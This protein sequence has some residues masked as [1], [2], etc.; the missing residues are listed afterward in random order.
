MTINLPSPPDDDP[1]NV[2]YTNRVFVQALFPYRNT[3]DYRRSITQGSNEV[4]ITSPNGL[5]YGKYPRLIMAYII[6]VAVQRAKQVE[7][8]LFTEEEARRIPL[9]ESLNEF[10]RSI[11]SAT[12]GTGGSNGTI[13]RI[14]EQ[15]VRL[16][17]STITVQSRMERGT[18]TLH[19]GVNQSIA[20]AWQLWFDSGNPDQT[21]LEESYIQLTPRF[22]EIICQSPIPIDLNVLQQLGK[23][24]AMDIYVWIT[25]KKAW[26]HYRNLPSYTFSW[27]EMEHQFST[28]KLT[29]SVQR[30]N[31]RNEFNG[32]LKVIQSLWPGIGVT[33]DT[34]SGVTIYKGAPSISM[35]TAKPKLP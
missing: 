9:G 30:R 18:K 5:P 35:K 20:E 6:T 16:A 13:T 4:I 7:K 3:D 29:D 26:L 27:N 24:R 33:T 34:K 28:S 10:F 11:G 12:R 2:G 15:L 31:F 32:C 21:T 22:F 8:G 23:P 1:Q 14:R 25:L 19:Q 17:S